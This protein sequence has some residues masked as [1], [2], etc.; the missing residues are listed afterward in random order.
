M[1]PF[2]RSVAFLLILLALLLPT[3][4]QAQDAED[5]TYAGEIEAPPFPNDLAWLNVE[6]PLTLED[7]RGKVVLLDFWTYGCINCI[8]VIPELKRLEAEFPTQLVVVGVHSA[9]FEGEGVTDNIRQIVQRYEVV[10]PIIN[11][12]EFE[13][14]RT[15]GVQAWPTIGLIDPL[16]RVV[17]GKPGEGVYDFFQPIIQTMVEEYGAAGLLNESPLP[18]R[19]EIE[20]MADTPLRFPGKV[21]VDAPGNRLF[22]ADSGHHRLVIT[23]LDS[24]EVL[25]VIGAGEIGLA[26][27]DYT[28]ARFNAPQGLSLDGNSLYVADTNNHAIRLV[29][30]QTQ[31]VTT[32]AGTGLMEV[33]QMQPGEALSTNLRS[34]WDVLAHEDILYIAMAGSHQL[35]TLDLSD[36]TLAPFAGN[37]RE[38]LIDGPRL[39]SELAQP[40]GLALAGAW[41]YFADSES[42]SIRRAGLGEGGVVE[43]VI[44]PVNEPQAR[45]FT[46]GDVDG[47]IDQA[48][49]QHPLAVTVDEAGLLYIADTY[50]NK[51]KLIDPVAQTSTTFAGDVDGGYFDGVG[52][53]ALFD[54]PGSLGYAEGKLYVADTNNH[55]IRVI[56]AATGEVSTV[57]FPN[58]SLLLE[59]ATAASAPLDTNLGDVFGSDK[60]IRLDPQTVAPGAGQILVDA[61][62]PFGYK[63]NAQ[64]PFTAV[65]ASDATVSLDDSQLSYQQIL[66]ELPIAFP[67]TLS[68]G[69]TELSVDLTIYWCEAINETLCFVERGTVVL[70]IT[71]SASAS[72]SDLRLDYTLT[73]PSLDGSLGN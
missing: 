12:S 72:S 47:G 69:Q 20:Q 71:V 11:D 32:I 53:E 4:A 68:E 73:P 22:I 46:F 13:V 9:K 33:S 66:P 16:G 51:I 30:L 40:S 25:H 61:V 49:L 34:P 57:L 21:L 52:G 67:V 63:L 59:E 45:L 43:T 8:H 42:S 2:Q 41:L 24:F 38:D 18:L 36:Q 58:V 14:W 56:E 19:P 17:G 62:M 15:Y 1:K 6:R 31:Q 27:G 39:E 10:H 3:F 26:D 29:D 64:A 44:G 50:N 48:R 70:P 55:A 35:W 60:V 54:E 28:T 7:L 65:W 5:F 23:T 37:G